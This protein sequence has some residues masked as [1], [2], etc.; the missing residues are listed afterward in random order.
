MNPPR[1]FR[2]F[3]SA[4]ALFFLALPAFAQPVTETHPVGT[5]L[6][7]W[8]TVDGVPPPSVEWFKNGTKFGEAVQVSPG[9]WELA[10]GVLASGDAGTYTA[11]ATNAAGS[12]TSDPFVIVVGV[13]PSKPVIRSAV[14]RPSDPGSVFPAS[15]SLSPSKK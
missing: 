8:V 2:R 1:P 6:T 12:A 11:K 9:R 15:G 7:L 5:H 10:I 13:V 4:L 3:A 14:K